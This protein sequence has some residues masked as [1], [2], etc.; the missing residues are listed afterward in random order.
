MDIKNQKQKHQYEQVNKLYIT[1]SY[2]I[3]N[4][5]KKVGICKKTY[6]NI[7][8]KLEKNDNKKVQKGGQKNII[9]IVENEQHNDIEQDENTEYSKLKAFIKG[10]TKYRNQ[11]KSKHD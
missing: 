8:N 2:T 4:A 9:D 1:G 3:E 5:C 7:K 11:D 10:G 6:Y